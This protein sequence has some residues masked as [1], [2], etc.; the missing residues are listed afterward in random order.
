MGEWVPSRVVALVNTEI[1]W[2]WTGPCWKSW[3]LQSLRSVQMFY[4]CLSSM[5]A[6]SKLNV[7][8]RAHGIYLW[9]REQGGKDRKVMIFSVFRHL[10]FDSARTKMKPGVQWGPHRLRL[11][12]TMDPWKASCS[13]SPLE[14]GHVPHHVEIR[15]AMKV[16]RQPS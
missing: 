2:P 16:C 1:V 6:C 14:T 4:F 13:V 12:Q 10:P 15:A 11:I 8:G 9:I 5:V 7:I 3:A